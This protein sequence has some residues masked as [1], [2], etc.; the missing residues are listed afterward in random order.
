M[1]YQE[2]LVQYFLEMFPG[3]D[4]IQ[5]MLEF[6]GLSERQIGDHVDDSFENVLSLF[7]KDSVPNYPIS[8]YFGTS[9]LWKKSFAAHNEWRDMPDPLKM[10]PFIA[11]LVIAANR[12]GSRTTFSCDGWHVDRDKNRQVR[13]ITYDPGSLVWLKVILDTFVKDHHDL[14]QYVAQS[15]VQVDLPPKDEGKLEIYRKINLDAEKI[16]ANATY[17]KNKKYELLKNVSGKKKRGLS[18]EELEQM[19]LDSIQL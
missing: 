6:R 9:T 7:E 1:S 3:Q 19:I 11:R 12:V 15:E 13:L 4:R 10:D 16:L 8:E 17:L 5:K 18:N 2:V 14:Y